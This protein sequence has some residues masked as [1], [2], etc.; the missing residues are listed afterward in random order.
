MIYIIHII[1]LSQTL[2]SVCAMYVRTYLVCTQFEISRTWA[3]RQYV[4]PIY[5]NCPWNVKKV[6]QKFLPAKSV[7]TSYAFSKAFTFRAP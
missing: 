5:E 4:V 2:N 3:I 1:L 7:L 6:G